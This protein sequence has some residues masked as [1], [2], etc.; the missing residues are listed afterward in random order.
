MTTAHRGL[1]GIAGLLGALQGCFNPS[2]PAGALCAEDGWCPSSQ[3]C[4][5]FTWTCVSAGTPDA[6]TPW[7]DSGWP[8]WPPPDSAV[9]WPDAGRLVGIENALISYGPVDIEIPQVLITYVK[10]SIEG[11]FA[12]FFVQSAPEGPALF[13]GVDPNLSGTRLAV[14]DRVSFR[15]L[16]MSDIAGLPMAAFI[17]SVVIHRRGEDARTLLQDITYIGDI[18]YNPYLYAAELV[19][20]AFAIEA[21]VAPDGSGFVTGQ[22]ATGGISGDAR[23]R[24]RMPES[25]Q[26]VAALEPGCALTLSAT[27][28]WRY[29]D[30]S[31][32]LA[33]TLADLRQ[34]DCPAPRIVDVTAETSTQ[35]RIVLSRGLNASSVR[36]DGAQFVF[37]NGVTATAAT[38]DGRVVTVTTTPQADGQLHTLTIAASVQ[39]VFGK[40]MAAPGNSFQFVGARTRAG[41]RINELKANITP[42]CDL[43]ELRITQDG[44]LSGFELRV[45][46]GTV[47]TFGD[48]RV[49]RNDLVVVHFD[50]LDAACNRNGSGNETQSVNEQPRSTFSSN[51]DT[52]YDWYTFNQ[53]PVVGAGVLAVRDDQGRVLD[54]VL[55][56][57]SN[58]LQDTNIQTEDAALEVSSAGEWQTQGGGV[59]PTGFVDAAFHQNAVTGI[60]ADPVNISTG[61]LDGKRSVQRSGNADSHRAG[62]WATAAHSF[63]LPNAGQ[64][65]L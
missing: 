35:V 45:Q 12:G 14:G 4:D 53:G 30:E 9:P 50:S 8:P 18:T 42:G 2:P 3:R 27:P 40:G 21:D 34:V 13:V 22:V 36:P 33:Y 41:V 29:W 39:D 56:T 64:T 16:E 19:S 48:V 52:A 49:A 58:L 43:V 44:N 37:D 31:H 57:T 46:G 59:P 6:G 20:V 60:D 62:D 10:P 65:P 17:D 5:S 38:V 61:T 55:V 24:L 32:L 54:A 1:I 26:D 63:G 7:V 25:L 51:F 23:L 11:D 47:L 15:V 28:L